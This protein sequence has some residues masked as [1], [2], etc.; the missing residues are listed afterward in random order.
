[1]GVARDLTKSRSSDTTYK[2]EENK[3]K[4]FFARISTQDAMDITSIKTWLR[5]SRPRFS[6]PERKYVSHNKIKCGQT[7]K[8]ML[9]LP[10]V[11]F[12]EVTCD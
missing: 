2:K 8:L 7:D 3:I 10:V 9:V 1:M 5:L 12:V 4:Q 11:R 6:N